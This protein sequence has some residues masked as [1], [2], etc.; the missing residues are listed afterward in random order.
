MKR[1]KVGS[2]VK[3]H[4]M[5]RYIF[6]RIPKVLGHGTLEETDMAPNSKTFEYD[7]SDTK[8]FFCR[9]PNRF[10]LLDVLFLFG[11]SLRHKSS[12]FKLYDRRAGKCARYYQAHRPQTGE[13]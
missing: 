10:V 3:S 8:N 13:S 9:N 6:G 4:L 2:L 7:I 1:L 11:F 5:V 12:E